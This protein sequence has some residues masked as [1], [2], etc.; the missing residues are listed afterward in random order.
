[1]VTSNTALADL[2][3]AVL[4]PATVTGLPGECWSSQASV[5]VMS[6]AFSAW[7]TAPCELGD[8]SEG[9]CS[10]YTLTC[11]EPECEKQ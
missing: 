9:A 6:T 10:D 1:M 8:P 4:L 2:P 7:F 11:P 5:Q 3:G